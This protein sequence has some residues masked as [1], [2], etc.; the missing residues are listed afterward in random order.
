MILICSDVWRVRAGKFSFISHLIKQVLK[1]NGD[2]M[3]TTLNINTKQAL[4]ISEA[5]YDALTSADKLKK[6]YVV[7]YMQKSNAAVAMPHETDVSFDKWDI[8]Y[9]VSAT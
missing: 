1:R 7:V 3:T 9:K 4:E 5:L 8:L 6:D 2:T